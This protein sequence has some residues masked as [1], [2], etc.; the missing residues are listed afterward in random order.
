MLIARDLTKSYHSGEHELTVLRD[1]LF[2]I[3]QGEFV[4]IVGPSGSGKTTLLGLLAGLDTPTRGTVLL[5]ESDLT[6]LSENDRA[7]L[8]VACAR[9]PPV[10]AWSPTMTRPEDDAAWLSR[11]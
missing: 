2:T 1:V 8:A 7:R 11:F 3:Q 9:N 5:D 4:A 6:K 10:R